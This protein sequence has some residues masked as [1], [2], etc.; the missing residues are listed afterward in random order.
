MLGI[1]TFLSWAALYSQ[2]VLL[3]D[4]G[5]SALFLLRAG[6]SELLMMKASRKCVYQMQTGLCSAVPANI[7]SRC[8][9]VLCV[10]QM[11]G[12]LDCQ[13][14]DGWM[15]GWMVVPGVCVDSSFDFI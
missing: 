1:C 8:E 5:W 15:V 12:L 7:S 4:T 2:P 10:T 11:L 6:D 9:C 3:A 14:G 13:G